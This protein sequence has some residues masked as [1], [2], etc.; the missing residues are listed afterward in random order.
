MTKNS[1][2]TRYYSSLQEHQIAK[3]LGGKCCAN[4]GAA[5]WAQGDVRLDNC[6]LECKTCVEKKKSF[7][8]KEDWLKKIKE[9]ANFEQKDYYAVAFNFGPKEENYY[10]IP[11]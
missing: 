3:E 9:E 4:S 7:S 5:F 11:Q 2:S 6:L 10:I 8:I 1:N